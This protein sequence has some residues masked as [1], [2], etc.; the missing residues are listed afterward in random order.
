M[1]SKAADVVYQIADDDI[2]AEAVA[3]RE[4][5]KLFDDAINDPLSLTQRAKCAR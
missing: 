5:F 3:L 4:G 1:I 2:V